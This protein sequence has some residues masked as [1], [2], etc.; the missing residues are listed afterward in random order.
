MTLRWC[1]EPVSSFEDS[2][3]WNLG[4][5]NLSQQTSFIVEDSRVDDTY[6]V[7]NKAQLQAPLQSDS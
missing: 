7:V 2:G 6:L 4:R 3:T 5:I 1:L